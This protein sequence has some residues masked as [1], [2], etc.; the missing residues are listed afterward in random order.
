MDL[1][2]DAA[3]VMSP[4]AAFVTTQML[5]DVLTIGT[6]KSLKAF[7]G[8]RP[9]A[10][11]TGTT[12]DYRDAWFIGYTPKLLTGV[13]VGHDTPQ[14]GGRGFTGGAIA[15]PIW[16][17]FM[18]RALAA[19]PPVDF[20]QPADVASAYVDVP[21]GYLATADCPDWRE[22]YFIAGTQPTAFCPDHGGVPLEL[23]P[24]V[25][26]PEAPQQQTPPVPV[27]P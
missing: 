3:Q 24:P 12:D 1:P 8:E 17:R 27:Q 13:W 6:A 5:R 14:P 20:P 11:K 25:P 2:A 23:P 18:R 15:A 21:T 7:A 19:A 16:E 22:E 4:A 26:E 9:A 10:G